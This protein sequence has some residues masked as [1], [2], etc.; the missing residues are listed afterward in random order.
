MNDSA[1]AG[2]R[3]I[4]RFIDAPSIVAGP[5]A[6]VD[7]SQGS[8]CGGRVRNRIRAK[9]DT[10]ARRVTLLGGTTFGNPM[11]PPGAYAGTVDPGG[12][13][14]DPTHETASEPGMCHLATPGDIYTSWPDDGTKEMARAVFNA[15]FMRFTGVD[16]ILEQL[17]EMLPFNFWEVVNAGRAI[18]RGGMFVAQGTG[19]HV[20]YH[21]DQCP[22]TG[23]TY[24]EY[25]IR[26][27]EQLAVTRLQGIVA[28]AATTRV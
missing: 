14:L 9:A 10:H 23:M 26:H 21:I 15:V 16:S 20:R 27:L 3:E 17:G 11:R 28:K 1:D 8:I 12:S 5:V 22:G 24:Y 6:F 2:E 25:G 4:H 19:P 18:L 7:Y 13:G